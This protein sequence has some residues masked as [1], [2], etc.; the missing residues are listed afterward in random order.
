MPCKLQGKGVFAHFCAGGGIIMKSHPETPSKTNYYLTSII[1]GT[2]HQIFKTFMTGLAEF[3]IVHKM[4]F[5]CKRLFFLLLYW[6]IRYHAL[7]YRHNDNF[8]ENF[9][10]YSP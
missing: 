4:P 2:A 10:R 3:T 7:S 9:N 5:S 1:I 6:P 8:L